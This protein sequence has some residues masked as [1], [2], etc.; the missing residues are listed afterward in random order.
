MRHIGTL[1]LEVPDPSRP[2]TATERLMLAQIGT[3]VED[4]RSDDPLR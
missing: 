3:I 1:D 2:L 4:L